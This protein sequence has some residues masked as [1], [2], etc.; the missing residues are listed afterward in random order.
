MPDFDVEMSHSR[1]EMTDF[2]TEM[3]KKT[4]VFCK[5]RT[6]LTHFRMRPVYFDQNFY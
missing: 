1:V 4:A 2:D 3:T 6:V 5:K